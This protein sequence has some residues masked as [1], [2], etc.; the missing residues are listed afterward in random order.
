MKR[1]KHEG[2]H[3]A[4]HYWQFLTGDQTGKQH[5]RLNELNVV[6]IQYKLFHQSLEKNDTILQ[7]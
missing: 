7:K 1:L 5:I 2:A 4:R 6:I 3:N